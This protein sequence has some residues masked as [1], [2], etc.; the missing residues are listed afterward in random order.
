MTTSD[1]HLEYLS[2]D[3][4]AN[5]DRSEVDDPGGHL[6]SGVTTRLSS[7]ATST[8]P[9]SYL[10]HD[11]ADT[12]EEPEEGEAVLPALR[13]GDPG[14]HGEHHQAQDVRGAGVQDQG[15]IN[16]LLA[17]KLGVERCR[18]L[19]LLSI[20]RNFGKKFRYYQQQLLQF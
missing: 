14:D 19:I 9:N 16:A 11:D 17:S 2:C 13:D 1:L 20:S 18:K 5:S 15:V 6:H 7:T 8:F 4:E 12:L 10:H 3:E